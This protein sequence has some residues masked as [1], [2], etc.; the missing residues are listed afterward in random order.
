MSG[1]PAPSGVVEM[2]HGAGGR[3][4]TDLIAAL[5]L[6][7]FGGTGQE[8]QATLVLPP[9]RVA[10]STDGFVISPLFFPGG[11]IGTLAV[12]GTVNDIA[13]GGARPLALTAGFVLEEGFALA[14]L[15]RIARSMGQAARAAGVRIVAGD[16]KVVER[17]K[18]DGVFITTAGIGVVRDGAC[19]SAC[20]ARP[21]DAVLVSGS[22]GDHGVAVMATRAGFDFETEVV[23]D[24]AALHDLAG[25]LLDAAPGCRLMR[26]PTRGGL[27]AVLNEIAQAS[28][29]G[30]ALHEA[31]VPVR[32]GVRGACELLG[33]DPLYVANEGKLVAV[34]PA[35]E[36]EAGLAALHAHPL[37]REAAIVG[38]VRDDPDRFVEME[39]L[40][41]GRRIVDW[42]AGEQLPRIC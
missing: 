35:A 31:R 42:I 36:A 29:V 33:L 4:M 8:D 17:G 22:M 34:L 14:D 37:G 26:D 2:R 12:N 32:P 28:R 38:E 39:T 3:D 27:A 40:L 10:L 19:L 18:G 41:G 20:N 7:A 1:A 6:S 30:I 9:G 11:D 16:T 24:C 5:F 23:S 21:G 13:M 15:A 25:A